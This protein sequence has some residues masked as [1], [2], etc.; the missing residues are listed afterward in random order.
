M[1][2]YLVTGVAGFIGSYVAKKLLQEGHQVT[3]I[4]NLSTVQIL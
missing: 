3:G 4:D 2:N 1:G